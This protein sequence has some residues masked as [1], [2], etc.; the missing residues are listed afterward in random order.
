MSRRRWLIVL[1]VFLAGSAIAIALSLNLSA[2]RPVTVEFKSSPAKLLRPGSLPD[3]TLLLSPRTQGRWF[4]SAEQTLSV[5][6]A[7]PRRIGTFASFIAATKTTLT[8]RALPIAVPSGASPHVYTSY[9]TASRQVTFALPQ[10]TIIHLTT[11]RSLAALRVGTPLFIGGVRAAV[12]GG[13][14]VALVTDLGDLAHAATQ[15]VPHLQL[16]ALGSAAGAVAPFAAIGAGIGVQRFL[17]AATASSADSPPP[18]GVLLRNQVGPPGI[19]WIGGLK[20]GDQGGCPYLNAGVELK[21]GAGAEWHWPFAFRISGSNDTLSVAGQ[22]QPEGSPFSLGLS[23][24]GADQSYFFGLGVAAGLDITIGCHVGPFGGDWTL[25]SIGVHAMLANETSK[26]APISGESDL[27]VPPTDCIAFGAQPLTA[28]PSWV[29]FAEKLKEFAEFAV[30]LCADV[31]LSGGAFHALIHGVGPAAGATPQGVALTSSGDAVQPP[32]T[33]GHSITIDQVNYQPLLHIGITGGAEIGSN[34]K[35]A[36]ALGDKLQAALRG[37]SPT[38]ASTYNSAVQQCDKLNAPPFSPELIS[39]EIAH[40]GVSAR[41]SIDWPHP[42]EMVSPTILGQP[43]TLN[44]TPVTV[45]T[46]TSSPTTTSQSTPVTTTQAPS[47]S[48]DG[49]YDGPGT[50][51][52]GPGTV[53]WGLTQTGNRIT[54]AATSTDPSGISGQGTLSGT[55]AGSTLM[56]TMDFPP[57]GNP[58]GCSARLSGI[59]EVTGAEIRGSYAGTSS[60]QGT[61]SNGQFTLR[62]KG[63]PPPSQG[64]SVSVT[65]AGGYLWRVSAAAPQAATQVQYPTGPTDAPPGK[66]YVTEVL[67]ITNFTTRPEPLFEANLVGTANTSVMMGFPAASAK[68]FGYDTYTASVYCRRGASLLPAGLC[69]LSVVDLSVTPPFPYARI[70]GGGSVDLLVASFSAVPSAA[71]LGQVT[72]YW[73]EGGPSNLA[74]VRIPISR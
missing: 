59:A 49:T 21:A 46:T 5:A 51:S 13:L 61:V 2:R 38:G 44:V 55:L 19:E 42:L 48:L 67:H 74:A 28:V 71:P 54:G 73:I 57:A 27:S 7:H 26:H 58:Y 6:R 66:E 24:P 52:T 16:A 11:G 68:A 29:P 65:D 63:T 17:S 56:F 9:S 45:V 62:K 32:L 3:P 33:T 14:L 20:L 60:C 25:A 36:L 50:D 64:P 34:A 69:E 53:T 41:I 70:P 35:A 72:A 8:V 40:L 18:N 4:A 30:S 37:G 23:D 31:R 15:R 10:Q 12:P 22:D 47:S 43:V 39:C 1:G